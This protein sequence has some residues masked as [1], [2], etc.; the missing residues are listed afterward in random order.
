[1][2][3]TI[4]V[5]CIEGWKNFVWAYAKQFGIDNSNGLLKVETLDRNQFEMEYK[6]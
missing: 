4:E 5:V 3:D 6:I 1:M 2:V